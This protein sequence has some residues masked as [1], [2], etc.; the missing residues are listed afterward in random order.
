MSPSLNDTTL[1][2][3]REGWAEEF[4]I[5]VEA[6]STSG[7]TTFTRD[8]THALV[9]VELW[10]A[11]VAVGPAAAIDRLERL[12]PE[13][14]C[15]LDAV[16][17]AL[18][19]LHPD[20]IAAASLSYVDRVEV[21][22]GIEVA[23]GPVQNVDMLRDRCTLE[24]W[25][26]SGLIDMPA[27]VAAR[28]PDGRVAAVAGY[29]RW[30][31]NLAQL[32]VLT[33]PEWRGMGYAAVAAARAAQVAQNEALVPQWRCRIGNTASEE[34]AVRLGFQRVGVQLAVVLGR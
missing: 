18:G 7:F 20:P 16:T 28:R 5:P 19:G 33:D 4:E 14:R 13:R 27:R 34:V 26:E 21:P 32:G 9:M 10:G 31:R 22:T 12:A 6:F 17:S 29:E 24:E 30:G 8:D 2:Q 25:E 3:V 23:V 1:A 15:D 11:H